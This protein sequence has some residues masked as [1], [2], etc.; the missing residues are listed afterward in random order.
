VKKERDWAQL[1]CLT[2]LLLWALL[3]I[4]IQ[5]SGTWNNEAPG[6]DEGGGPFAVI[7]ILGLILFFVIFAI[8]GTMRAIATR[9]HRKPR[10]FPVETR[11]TD[12]TR[13][14]GQ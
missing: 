9:L 11:Q 6:D 8:R 13:E 12:D 3:G 5:L 4:E 10:R 2:L 7:G 14:G 1:G